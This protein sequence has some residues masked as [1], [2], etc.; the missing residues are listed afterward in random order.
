[1]DAPKGEPGVHLDHLADIG[2]SVSLSDGKYTTPVKVIS[3]DS[4]EWW[5]S[6]EPWNWNDVYGEP[7]LVRAEG[8]SEVSLLRKHASPE[9]PGSLY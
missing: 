4:I 5:I 2:E 8:S 9:I 6:E 1:M 7:I 3:R